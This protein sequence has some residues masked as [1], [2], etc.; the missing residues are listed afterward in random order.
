MS[1][2]ILENPVLNGV[3]CAALKQ[4]IRDVAADPA[5]AQ[6]KF[7]V[8]T[9]WRGG[10]VSETIVDGYE[11]GGRRIAKNFTIRIDEPL[12]LCGTNSQPNPQEMLMAAF[13]ACMLVGYVAGATLH[14]IELE[15]LVIS[16]HGDLDLR[17]FLGL[18]AA[19]KPGYDEIH[20]VVRIKGNGTREQ[21]EEIHRTVMATS[22]NRWNIANPI[23]LT[24]ELIAECTPAYDC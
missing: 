20:Y 16:T 7:G 19:V 5:N 4:L 22:P 13:N 8:T 14:G 12:E 21:F 3:D 10:V 23:R 11:L 15:E 2:A 1:T 6:V 9:H 24:S 18:D 17:G